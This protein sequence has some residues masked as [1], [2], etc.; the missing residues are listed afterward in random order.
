MKKIRKAV[1]DFFMRTAIEIRVEAMWNIGN[2]KTFWGWLFHVEANKFEWD[3][4]K[5]VPCFWVQ[6]YIRIIGVGIGAGFYHVDELIWEQKNRGVK[7]AES[8]IEWIEL[9]CNQTTS[10]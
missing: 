7:M 3:L 1:A 2:T 9:T 10:E 8:S 4:R 5:N 6:V